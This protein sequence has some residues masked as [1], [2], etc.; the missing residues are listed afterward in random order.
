MKKKNKLIHTLIIILTFAL[1]FVGVFTLDPLVAFILEITNNRPIAFSLT[2]IFF[3][4]V[5]YASICLQVIIHESGHLVCGLISGYKFVSFRIF[6][7]C[8]LK[9]N[10][11]IRIKKN[12]IP[13]TLGQ[14]LMSPPSNQTN[15]KLP[16]KLF[17]FGGTLFNLIAVTVFALLAFL[18]KTSPFLLP[19]FSFLSI[20]GIILAM[21]N[22]IPMRAGLLQNDGQNV[23]DISKSQEA[24]ESFLLQLNVAKEQTQGAT[25]SQM[26]DEWFIMPEDEFI[27]NPLVAAKVYFICEREIEKGNFYDAH[28]LIRR[29]FEKAPSLLPLYKSILN[30]ELIYLDAIH[31]WA[32]EASIL[33]RLRSEEKTLKALQLNPSVNRVQYAIALLVNK[34]EKKANEYLALFE[35]CAKKYP[36][37]QEIE[38]ERKLI[39]LAKEKFSSLVE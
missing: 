4:I 39:A 17:N 38:T 30:L 36:Y 34:D 16:Y 7:L 12:S 20:T 18:L 1:V 6:S 3:L 14:C 10:G 2:L 23:I 29:L 27:D 11:K 35:K 28:V 31:G 9:V 21:N 19:I 13:G 8:F 5:F 22:G 15:A 26:P 37:P 25:L 24:L 33:K 32:P